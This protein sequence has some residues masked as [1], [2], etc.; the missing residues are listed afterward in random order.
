MCESEGASAEFFRADKMSVV[1]IT[2][3]L[4]DARLQLIPMHSIGRLP[5][6]AQECLNGTAADYEKTFQVFSTVHDYYVIMHC[7]AKLSEA[8]QSCFPFSQN[9]RD[10]YT[11]SCTSI[12]NQKGVTTKSD[13]LYYILLY[14]ITLLLS[15]MDLHL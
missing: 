8:F 6:K 10:H 3:Y 11:I 13:T 2:P 7:G 4:V 5:I 14:K 12:S 15:P 9:N 1:S